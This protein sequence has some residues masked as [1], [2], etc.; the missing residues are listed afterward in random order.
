M[1]PKYLRT[2]SQLDFTN[3]AKQVTIFTLVNGW[4]SG[5]LATDR[6]FK[7]LLNYAVLLHTYIYGFFQ[8][9]SGKC[10]LKGSPT[11]T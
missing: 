9:K 4:A 11:V 5:C 8:V 6:T 2:L 7:F 3:R 10:K 1:N